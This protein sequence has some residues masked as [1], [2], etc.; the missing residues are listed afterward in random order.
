M[1][2][3][4]DI[5]LMPPEQVEQL[6]QMALGGDLG[7]NLG[8]WLLGV[9]FDAIAFGIMIQ[10][11]Q[12]WWTYSKDSERRLMSW[13]T[14]YINLNQIGWTA[15]IIFF[16]MHYFVYN[17][18]RFSVFLDVKLAMIFP[19]W[20]WTVSGPIKFFYIERTWKLNGKNIFLGILLC[21]LNVAE[22][23]M[24]IYLTWKFSTLSSG[25]EAAACILSFAF[26]P[27]NESN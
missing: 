19:T 10:Q 2:E 17:F 9:I 6:A 24:C 27:S 16:G 20:G 23:G 13:L 22:C 3:V 18:G 14:H 25:L 21:C 12:T 5:A 26:E 8:P 11:Y 15:Y 7:F 1:A 4:P